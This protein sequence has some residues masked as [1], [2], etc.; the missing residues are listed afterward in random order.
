MEKVEELDSG[1][2]RGSNASVM[3]GG[4]PDGALPLG[5]A[6]DK[7]GGPEQ[8]GLA[9]Q[10]LADRRALANLHLQ[11]D[12][13]ITWELVH[14][15]FTITVVTASEGGAKFWCGLLWGNKSAGLQKK[16]HEKEE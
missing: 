9:N 8:R 6:Q 4:L 7:L 13:F 11:I 1:K 15:K 5:D 14:G 12:L 16:I 10:R 2:H 3:V